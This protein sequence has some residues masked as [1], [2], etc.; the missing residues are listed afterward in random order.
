M[1]GAKSWRKRI[2]ACLFHDADTVIQLR[3]HHFTDDVVFLSADHTYFSFNG[4]A[5]RMRIFNDSLCRFDV[6]VDWAVGVIDHN[7]SKPSIDRFFTFLDA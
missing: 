5:F 4:Y 3:I 7:R 1:Y 2:N 6:R